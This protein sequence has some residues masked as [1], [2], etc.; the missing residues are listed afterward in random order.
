MATYTPIFT[1][2]ALLKMKE[3]GLSEDDVLDVF[4]HGAIEKANFARLHP[5]GFG[6]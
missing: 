2:H 3:W 5:L 1:N 4:N 6:G